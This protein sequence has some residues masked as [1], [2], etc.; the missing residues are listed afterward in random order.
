[1]TDKA[2]PFCQKHL[3]ISFFFVY[4]QIRNNNNN[5]HNNEKS[6]SN[7]LLRSHFR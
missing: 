7:P 5:T 3:S 4:L 2:V 1:M 6:T